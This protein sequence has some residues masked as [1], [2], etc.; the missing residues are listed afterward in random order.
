MPNCLPVY[1][2]LPS[3]PAPSPA[4]VFP[5]VPCLCLSWSPPCS[6]SLPVCQSVYLPLTPFLQLISVLISLSSPPLS[7]SL[8][9]LLSSTFQSLFLFYR[10][11]LIPLMYSLLLSLCLVVGCLSSC[12]LYACLPPPS[13]LPPSPDHLPVYHVFYLTLFLFPC[14]IHILCIIDLPPYNTW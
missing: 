3:F 6:A 11:I 4:F 5:L 7:V 12:I 9:F 8:F 13:P 14:Q 10:S 2:P 1:L